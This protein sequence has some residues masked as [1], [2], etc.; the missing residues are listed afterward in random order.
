M[1][2]ADRIAAQLQQ[3]I[4][5]RL[6]G[7]SGVQRGACAVG[8][9]N[10]T[11]L[12][13]AKPGNRGGD[14]FTK[15]AAKPRKRSAAA[16]TSCGPRPPAQKK[17]GGPTPGKFYRQE[18]VMICV[19][20][21]SCSGS[22]SVTISGVELTMDVQSAQASANSCVVNH[23]E[24]A[25][26]LTFVLHAR[27]T[28]S[29]PQLVNVTS[30]FLDTTCKPGSQCTL[31]N[32]GQDHV[33]GNYVPQVKVE[34]NSSVDLTYSNDCNHNNIAAWAGEFALTVIP[35]VSPRGTSLTI[36]IGDTPRPA[37]V[38]PKGPSITATAGVTTQ[39]PSGTLHQIQ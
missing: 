12:P 7:A 36:N 3:Q 13:T 14:R 1:A 24:W 5:Q 19:S 32:G 27:N 38:K 22:S 34:P 31:T 33:I 2:Q 39:T 29:D 6:C 25:Q 16:S 21:A 23:D 4:L 35:Y 18:R 30:A 8:G 20:G 37:C 9:S 17:A 26:N 11:S 10:V 28:T 15:V